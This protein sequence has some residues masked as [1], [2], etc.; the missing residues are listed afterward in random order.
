MHPE[1]CFVRTYLNNVVTIT[2]LHWQRFLRPSEAGDWYPHSTRCC[3]N[4]GLGSG[5]SA[6]IN[7][8]LNPEVCAFF[9]S[10]DVVM[11]QKFF[12]GNHCWP[13]VSKVGKVGGGQCLVVPV[14]IVAPVVVY[15]IIYFTFNVQ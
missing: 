9:N 2:P 8:V 15:V 5:V 11:C 3:I 13:R 1:R 12:S 14:V 10:L 6:R 7:F 4:D